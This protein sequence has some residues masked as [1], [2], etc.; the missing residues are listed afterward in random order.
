MNGVPLD[1]TKLAEFYRLL[2]DS[3]PDVTLGSHNNL[4]D[5]PSSPQPRKRARRPR[6]RNQVDSE[7]PPSSDQGEYIHIPEEDIRSSDDDLSQTEDDETSSDKELEATD[8][9]LSVRLSGEPHCHT[10]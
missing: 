8:L 2:T 4:E 7:E 5:G 6:M 10:K 3:D 1:L 9:Y